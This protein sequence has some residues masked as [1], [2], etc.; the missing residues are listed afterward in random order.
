MKS[1]DSMRSIHTYFSFTCVTYARVARRIG[2]E[3]PRHYLP[4]YATCHSMDNLSLII[5]WNIFQ[6]CFIVK[7]VFVYINDLGI[8]V[9]F[10]LR[11][12]MNNI[13]TNRTM[14]APNRLCAA[15]AGPLRNIHDDSTARYLWFLFLLLPCIIT[16][17]IRFLVLGYCFPASPPTN[18]VQPSTTRCPRCENIDDALLPPI[19]C[20]PDEAKPSAEEILAEA[21]RRMTETPSIPRFILCTVLAIVNMT[22]MVLLAFTIQTWMYC[23]SEPTARTQ[24]AVRKQTADTIAFWLI[25]TFTMAWVSS[26]ILCWAMWMRNLLGGMEA[27]ERWPIRPD[28]GVLVVLGATAVLLIVL[29]IPLLLLGLVAIGISKW[30][31]ILWLRIRRRPLKKDVE[32]EMEGGTDFDGSDVLEEEGEEEDIDKN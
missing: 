20:P 27:A 29:S 17:W 26:G 32:V 24:V 6:Q 31:G 9:H 15:L 14:A 7:D 11:P 25:Y 16:G 19:P 21:K 10:H 3:L 1:K 5:S 13:A 22:A 4:R 2:L 12:S 8:Q 28:L 30:L 23:T 18:P